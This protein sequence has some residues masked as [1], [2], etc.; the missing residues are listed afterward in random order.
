MEVDVNKIK[1]DSGIDTIGS[2]RY[3]FET[4]DS[5]I[6]IKLYSDTL[7]NQHLIDNK[8]R[9]ELKKLIKWLNTQERLEWIASKS[10]NMS[11][12]YLY[13]RIKAAQDNDFLKWWSEYN[14]DID[15][16]LY[17]LNKWYK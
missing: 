12:L 3:Y 11:D 8:D 6:Y 2:G 16:F 10:F 15:I 7:F 14:F 9:E 17:S 13:I 1:T 4:E 5:N